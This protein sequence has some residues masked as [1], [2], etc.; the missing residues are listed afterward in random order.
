MPD[1]IEVGTIDGVE[2]AAFVSLR[3]P[4]WHGL[5]TVLEEE[6]NTQGMLDVAH[7]SDWNVRVEP[8][9]VP[10]G[11]FA[12]KD[13][14]RTVRTS[15]FGGSDI[16]GYVGER[17]KPFQN[18]ELFAFG[19]ALLDGGRWE[20]GGSIKNGTKVFGSLALDRGTNLGGDEVDN[21]LLVS[22]SH[23]GSAAI[24]ASVTPIRVVCANTLNIA[25]SSAKQTFKIRHTQSMQGK[26][27]AAREA[28][29]LADTYLDEWEKEMEAM[30]QAT[31]TN[32]QF[33]ELIQSIYSPND[34]KSGRTRFEKRHDTIWDIWGSETIKPIYGT[35]YGAYNA[36]NEELMWNRGGRGDNSLENVAASRSGFNPVWNAENNALFKAVKA[37]VPASA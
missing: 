25:L 34:T 28:L 26:V 9:E 11:Y 13:Q 10:D 21:Y 1:N 2:V 30:T 32:I 5:G 29:A 14:F 15:P 4:A 20:T 7:L 36:L 24:Q 37:L 18:E 19:D 22:T 8:V 23:D 27:Q 35:A 16:L 12:F 17:Y 6:V 33:E 31:I 3:E